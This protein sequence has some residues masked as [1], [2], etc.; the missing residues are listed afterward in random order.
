MLVILEQE[1]QITQGYAAL[2]QTDTGL[3]MRQRSR[4]FIIA[5]ATSPS[6]RIVFVNAGTPHLCLVFFP[7]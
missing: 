6:N 2:N 5:D 3:H 7:L 1:S 4:A